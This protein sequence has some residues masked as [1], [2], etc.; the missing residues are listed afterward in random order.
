MP[1]E[2][3]EKYTKTPLKT[4]SNSVKSTINSGQL[5]LTINKKAEAQKTIV[6][7]Q[8]QELHRSFLAASVLGPAHLT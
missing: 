4:L 2:C 5:R 7:Q 8:N 1:E 6:L 3:Y